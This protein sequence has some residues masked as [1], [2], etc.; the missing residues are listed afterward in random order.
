MRWSAL[1]SLQDKRVPMVQQSPTQTYLHTYRC[2]FKIY[3]Q[4]CI[5]NITLT[6]SQFREVS[7][8][9]IANKYLLFSYN[10]TLLLP[11]PQSDRRSTTFYSQAVVSAHIPS[12]SPLATTLTATA[13]ASRLQAGSYH[14]SSYVSHKPAPT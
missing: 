10:V 4:K 8:A 1:I 5:H 2:T 9:K 11:L 12:F 13:I 3:K 7:F 14:V 6:S